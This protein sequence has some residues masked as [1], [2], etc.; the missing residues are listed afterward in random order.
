MSAFRSLVRA[1]R[2][3]IPC[4]LVLAVLAADAALRAQAVAPTPTPPPGK[5]TRTA[6]IHATDY[7]E[8]SAAGIQTL[9]GHVSIAIDETTLL[10][11]LA[12][13]N[14]KTD[15]AVSPGALRIDDGRNT[16]TGSKGTAYY[17][18]RDAILQGAV[19]IVVRPPAPDPNTH[20]DP[21]KRAF[22]DPVTITCD[23]V[24]Y[25]WRVHTAVATGHLTLKQVTSEGV[26][27]TATADLL[28]F[29][30]DLQRL[31]LTG[32]VHSVD[33]KG[34]T[35]DG[36]EA[37]SII[38]EGAE[39]F[40]MSSFNATIEIPSDADSDAGGTTP[41]AGATP[42]PAASAGAAPGSSAP[43]PAGP[44]PAK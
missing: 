43:P 41:A 36:D 33:S 11:E 37:V 40:H 31:T 5:K 13:Y 32:H 20:S 29:E 19:T 23:R 28:R 25:N 4:A 2:L 15:I 3:A 17:R 35:A 6:H 26:T 34:E 8:V 12:E 38:K 21:D 22:K 39:E 44:P 10:T 30:V 42:A 7:S 24:D 14:Q 16:I 1:R 9:R 27:R 18:I